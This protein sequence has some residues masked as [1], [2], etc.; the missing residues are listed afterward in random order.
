MKVPFKWLKE[1][2]ELNISDEELVNLLPLRT[3]GTK[4]VTEN[5]M[6]LDMKGYNRADLLS[7]KGV[8]REVA[9]ITDS[10]VTFPYAF[11][12][13]VW[14][15]ENND[16]LDIQA[17]K[18]GLEQ[19]FVQVKTPKLVPVY[20]L[21]KIE[22][23]KVSAS[24]TE[25][26]EKL[27]QSGMRSVNNITDITNLVMLEYGQPLHAFDS[28]GVKDESIIVRSAKPGEKLTTL[29]GKIRELEGSDLLIADTEKP[30][31]IAGVMGGKDSEVSDST[32]TILLEAAIFDSI[33]LRKTSQR[34]GIYSE[35]AKRFQHG[36]T[37]TGL[38]DALDG[39][40][41]M[42][43]ELGGK[44][45]GISIFYERPAHW[46]NFDNHVSVPLQLS[47]VNQLVGVNF[48]RNEVVSFLKRLQF[49]LGGEKRLDN[50]V[51]W[52]VNP[53]YY[54]L[55]IEI[56]ED[57]IEEIARLYGYEKILTKELQGKLPEKIDQ[58]QFNLINNLRDKFVQTGFS[59]VQTYSFYTIKTLEALG[60]N[61]EKDLA[62]LIKLKNP[63]SSETEY[64]RDML[65]PNL[66]EVT[67]KNIRNGFSDVA[68]FEIGKTYKKK[69]QGIVEV[70]FLAA[71][72]V[73]GS[74]NP[75]LEMIGLLKQIFP[76]DQG[77]KIVVEKFESE[78][79][80]NIFH[81]NRTATI[82][83][84]D[85]EVGGI[86]EIHQRVTDKFGISTRLASMEIN[87]DLL[88]K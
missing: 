55:D 18:E 52:S 66:A 14:Q 83:K 25:L 77:Y 84:G 63:M 61:N 19:L 30:L 59:E 8:A 41:R 20:C 46:T 48:S 26:K 70:N 33:T 80:K 45:V 2:V 16:D 51:Q 22:G 24:P 82:Y 54:R 5:F 42:Y 57:V 86:A 44:L 21:A 72:L 56:E 81:P 15:E 29:D 10:K 36:L 39:A 76:E 78:W 85:K 4:E 3:I 31:G 65:W 9:A 27:E 1:L 32:T 17:V 6:E 79:S 68:I 88:T 23:L 53:P 13:H 38:F 37:K 62:D 35:A 49:E 11:Q 75:M 60:W 67:D 58:S 64:L 40:I 50:D 34:L 12:N 87:L 69:E 74:D 73:N 28:A 71:T 47:R 7:M 43:Q